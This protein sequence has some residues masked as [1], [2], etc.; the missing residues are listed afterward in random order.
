RARALAGKVA[1][2]RGIPHHRDKPE[3]TALRQPFGPLV[4]S[5]CGSAIPSPGPALLPGEKKGIVPLQTKDDPLSRLGVRLPVTSYTTGVGLASVC[6]RLGECRCWL[7][8]GW[9]SYGLTWRD[10]HFHPLEHG[11]ARFLRDEWLAPRIE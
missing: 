8:R 11:H 1:R 9:D 7:Q 2:R 4:D 6:R 10:R 3:W 5:R